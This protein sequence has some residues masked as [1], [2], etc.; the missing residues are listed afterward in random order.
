M[1]IECLVLAQAKG[2]SGASYIAPL[3]VLGIPT[4]IADFVLDNA[5]WEFQVL[6]TIK[7]SADLK[8]RGLLVV[9]MELFETV[10]GMV[11]P[12]RINVVAF[13]HEAEIPERT[14]AALFEMR[15]LTLSD[16]A[17]S[18]STLTEKLPRAS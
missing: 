1:K 9:K 7:R 11:N 12:E 16:N 3:L 4:T 18:K 17:T 6:Q 10:K 14:V 15:T 2:V 8:A 13:E 5:S